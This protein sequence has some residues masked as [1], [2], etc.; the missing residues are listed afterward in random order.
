MNYMIHKPV[1]YSSHPWPSA[2]YRFGLGGWLARQGMNMKDPQ[3]RMRMNSLGI[4]GPS[5]RFEERDVLAATNI[6]H[7][8]NP[9]GVDFLQRGDPL[10]SDHQ[11]DPIELDLS[12]KL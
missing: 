9:I 10:K 6:I 7:K 3:A 5:S 8:D 2:N 11:E 4:L 12:L 1:A